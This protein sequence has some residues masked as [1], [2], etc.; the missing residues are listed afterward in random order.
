M[1]DKAIIYTRPDGGVGVFYPAKA[2]RGIAA[3]PGKP[4]MVEPEEWWLARAAARAVPEAAKDVQTVGTETIPTDR[5]FRD[6]W[7]QSAGKISVDMPRAREVQRE[8]LRAARAPLLEALDVS[9]QRADE[10]KDEAAKKRVAA[11]KQR[12]RDVT[13]HPAIDAA[14]TP[15][16][17]KAAW[18]L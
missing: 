16:Q 1:T 15:E 14:K 11:E 5:T 2:D 13:R 7:V 9:Y 4:T 3:V 12:L 6:A 8:R 17:L 18:P 10:A